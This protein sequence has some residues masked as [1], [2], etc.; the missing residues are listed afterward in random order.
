MVEREMK[1]I[2][3]GYLQTVVCCRSASRVRSPTMCNNVL[4]YHMQFGPVLVMKQENLPHHH[5]YKQINLIGTDTDYSCPYF[6][7]Y[8]PMLIG[9]SLYEILF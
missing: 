7:M 6:P 3:G 4:F 1:R 2:G 9:Q 8:L 5:L